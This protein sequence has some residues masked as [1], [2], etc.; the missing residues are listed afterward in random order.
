MAVFAALDGEPDDAYRPGADQSFDGVDAGVQY[1][2]APGLSTRRRMVTSDARGAS[3]LSASGFLRLEGIARVLLRP[4]A[5][6]TSS[7][8]LA[9][10]PPLR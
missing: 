5:R 9:T 7:G 6:G 1:S 2:A 4:G 8:R 10:A 3:G